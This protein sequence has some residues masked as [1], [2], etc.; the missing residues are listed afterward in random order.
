MS[1]WRETIAEAASNAASHYKAV[2]NPKAISIFT[3]FPTREPLSSIG[4]SPA[5]LEFV[6]RYEPLAATEGLYSHQATLLKAYRSGK[7][8][9]FI[10]TSATG[11]GKSLCFWS[12]VIDHVIKQ[13]SATAVLC[14]P[15]QA[16]MWGQADRLARISDKGSLTPAGASLAFG[17]EV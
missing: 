12:W 13:P 10:L 3:P 8:S 16:L 15:T 17:G 9:N 7:G 14:F 5:V 1:N 11:S 2:L 6:R 4:L